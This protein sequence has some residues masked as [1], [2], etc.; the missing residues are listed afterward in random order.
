ME[1]S[2]TYKT[3][4]RFLDNAALTP[5][6][7]KRTDGRKTH[8]DLFDEKTKTDTALT[9]TSRD[10]IRIVKNQNG[11]VL[12][13]ETLSLNAIVKAIVNV[14]TKGLGTLTLTLVDGRKT[15]LKTVGYPVITE[16]TETMYTDDTISLDEIPETDGI[17]IYT[18]GSC[19]CTGPEKGIGSWAYVI[20]RNGKKIAEARNGKA[21]TNNTEMEFLAVL[22]ALR[23]VKRLGIKEATICSDYKAL[24]DAMT[25]PPSVRNVNSNGVCLTFSKRLHQEVKNT[26]AVV[27]WEWIKGH[28]NIQ[29]NSYVDE[30]ANEV[31]KRLTENAKAKEAENGRNGKAKTKGRS[32]RKAHN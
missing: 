21:G 15:Q 30:R 4:E 19:G 27:H 32:P 22:Y 24:I 14:S 12:I 7:R 2:E 23:A 3:I 11:K 1:K 29:W 18:D 13:T 20:V 16:E 5:L 9:L 31:R 26:G 17:A 25:L 8:Y 6:G 28:S 10:L